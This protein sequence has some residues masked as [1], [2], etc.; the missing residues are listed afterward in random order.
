MII[1]LDNIIKIYLAKK[2][3]RWIT[4]KIYKFCR[5]KGV[6]ISFDI[7]SITYSMALRLNKMYLFRLLLLLQIVLNK[8]SLLYL[9]IRLPL[10]LTRHFLMLFFWKF[11]SQV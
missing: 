2:N 6:Q 11:L 8:N 5:F 3:L 1:V 4:Q 7:C 10:E 9:H